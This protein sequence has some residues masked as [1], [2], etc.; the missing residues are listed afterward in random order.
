M[1]RLSERDWATIA[2][3]PE[4]MADWR[5]EHDYAIY[6]DSEHASARLMRV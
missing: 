6:A 3:A 1:I 5:W 2:D 4:L